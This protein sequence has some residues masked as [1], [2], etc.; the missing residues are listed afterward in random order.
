MKV[1]RE[2]VKIM[3][4][5]DGSPSPIS[6]G[7]SH[8]PPSPPL[9]PP[10]LP[11]PPLTELGALIQTTRATINVFSKAKAA[12]L[13]RELVDQFLDMRASTGNEVGS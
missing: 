2:K 1:A 8:L 10:P 5:A 9:P 3:C 7:V 13:I 6:V 4:T 11:P 12:K